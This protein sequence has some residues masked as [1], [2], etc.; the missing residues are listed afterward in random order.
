[1][2]V[3]TQNRDSIKQSNQITPERGT[4]LSEMWANF[5]RVG[6]QMVIGI[7][8]FVFAAIDGVL[9]AR[10]LTPHPDRSVLSIVGI[11]MGFS[12]AID[13]AYMLFTAGPD[14]AVDPLIVG[15]AATVLIFLGETQWNVASG[16]YILG[17]ALT[18][19]LLVSAIGLLLY[20]RKKYLN[21]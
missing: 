2:L 18:M 15:I 9:W 13:L 14:E 20:V 10:H 5:A 6:M 12:A 3:R 8:I 1:M 4:T 16:R 7:F 21:S 11:A 19:V 17:H